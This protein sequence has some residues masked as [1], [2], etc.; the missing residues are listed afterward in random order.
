VLAL[1][2][3]L[4]EILARRWQQ[5]GTEP[6]V[7]HH[8][9]QPIGFY[10]RAWRQ[11]CQQAG[12]ANKLFHDLRRTAVRN[13]MRAGV[14]DT[15]ALFISGHQTRNMVDRYNIVHE[16]DLRDAMIKTTQYVSR[17]YRQRSLPAQFPHNASQTRRET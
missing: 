4:I 10:Y 8:H 12:L 13:M 2:E 9:G 17:E 6:W 5:R 14:P 11:A 1:P 3:A 7:F 16:D 15:T